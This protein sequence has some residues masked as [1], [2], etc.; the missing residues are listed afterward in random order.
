MTEKKRHSSNGFNF[1]KFIRRKL[2]KIHE[3]EPKI[4]PRD[5]CALID[6]NKTIPAYLHRD[7]P[8]GYKS[9]DC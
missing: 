5:A 3:R 1:E 7:E 8:I 4:T 6:E 2:L 9:V